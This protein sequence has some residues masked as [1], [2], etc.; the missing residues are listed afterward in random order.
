M[1]VIRAEWE[2]RNIGVDCVEL[3]A[4]SDDSL[5]EFSSAIEQLTAEYQVIRIPAG[6]T[7]MLLAAQT[8]GYRV[9]E[10]NAQLSRSTQGYTLPSIY[11]RFESQID[12]VQADQEGVR[13]ALDE[14]RSAN[15]FVTDRVAKDP[16]FGPEKAGNR[17]YHW[18][19]D[20]LDRGGRLYSVMYGNEAV[21][22]ALN[23]TDD[24]NTYNA[25]LGGVFPGA[26]NKGLGFLPLH[27][28]VSMIIAQGGK[29]VVTGVS[30][31]NLPILRLHLL[32]GFTIQT[33]SYVLIKHL[34]VA[35]HAAQR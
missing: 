35:D 33:M 6:R 7:D 10:M 27:A 26:A 13:R 25:F 2:K 18:S 30:T 11:R 22:F 8:L 12:I 15:V 4:E 28:N 21:G 23:Y 24:G 20:V 31:N 29:R 14:I 5:N 17:Y 1:Q 34:R 16:F 3:N 19:R 32:F 9:I